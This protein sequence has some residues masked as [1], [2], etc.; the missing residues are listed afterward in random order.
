[1]KRKLIFIMVVALTTWGIQ[2]GVNP[3][4]KE[5]DMDI[6]SLAS[7]RL[8]RNEQHA[9]SALPRYVPRSMVVGI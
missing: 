5:V 9:T 7:H 4:V 2:A 6:E 3:Q 8:Y 1:M